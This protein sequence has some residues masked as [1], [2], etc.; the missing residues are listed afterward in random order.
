MADEDA[1]EDVGQV[2]L[3]NAAQATE[4]PGVDLTHLT[5]VQRKAALIAMNTDSCSCGCQLTVAECRV[6]DPSCTVS[7]EMAKA[8]VEKV[9]ATPQ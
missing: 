7:P 8:I 1:F 4:I 3:T 6:N 9:L 2:S 5:P